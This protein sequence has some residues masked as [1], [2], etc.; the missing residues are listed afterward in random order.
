MAESDIQNNLLTIKQLQSK[1]H[2]EYI[3]ICETIVNTLNNFYQSD[4]YILFDT[5]L[6]KKVVELDVHIHNNTYNS[7]LT[8]FRYRH[9]DPLCRR[10]V[11]ITKFSAFQEFFSKI[12]SEM[13]EYIIEI[14]RKVN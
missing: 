6:K 3:K 2:L 11:H 12:L 13:N 5:Y 14:K 9:I 1:I 4:D 10:M 8:T 7:V